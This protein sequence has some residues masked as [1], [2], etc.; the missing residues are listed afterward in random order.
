MPLV[1]F[2]WTISISNISSNY[3]N[4][5]LWLTL[6]EMS[7][8]EIV[9]EKGT[10]GTPLDEASMDAPGCIQMMQQSPGAVSKACRGTAPNEWFSVGTGVDVGCTRLTISMAS[11]VLRRFE[12]SQWPAGQPNARRADVRAVAMT[13]ARRRRAGAGEII[14]KAYSRRI[15]EGCSKGTEKGTHGVWTS[16]VTPHAANSWARTHARIFPGVT[17]DMGEEGTVAAA[18]Y[19]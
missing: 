12:Y 3:Y 15:L 1:P 4:L 16:T 7:E 6:D 5:G 18:Q 19:P 2:S 11:S 17:A 14:R 10:S 13:S 8:M 9:Q